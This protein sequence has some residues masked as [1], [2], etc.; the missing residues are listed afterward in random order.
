MNFDTFKRMMEINLNGTVYCAAHCA[1]YMS[2]NK[3]EEKGVILN[4]A[5]VA[6]YEAA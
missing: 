1:F 4:I 3:E 5:S 6:A 2:K